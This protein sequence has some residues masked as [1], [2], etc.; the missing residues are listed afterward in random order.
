MPCDAEG[1]GLDMLTI[2]DGKL[3]ARVALDPEHVESARAAGDDGGGEPVVAGDGRRRRD[4]RS[5]S[6]GQGA[7]E[8]ERRAASGVE[9]RGLWWCTGVGGGGGGGGEGRA[10]GR[11]SKVFD[12]WTGLKIKS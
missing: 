9:G 3:G 1:V 2:G 10:E 8:R 11:V 6:R 12:S 4:R 7:D 5:H